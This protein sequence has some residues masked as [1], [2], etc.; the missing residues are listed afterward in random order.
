MNDRHDL[1]PFITGSMRY[2]TPHSKSDID[3]AVFVTEQ[4]LAQ[5]SSMADS[6]D[7]SQCSGPDPRH[8]LRF[9]K[10][11]LLCFT[12]EWRFEV[13]RDVSAQLAGR[14][15]MTREEAIRALE[16]GESFALEAL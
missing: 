3:L 8:S 7:V 12:E 15:P 5:L 14:A 1:R 13:W 16:E 9:G 6:T 10:L 11:N 4:Q 2:G